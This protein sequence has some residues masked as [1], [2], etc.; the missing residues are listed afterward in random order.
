MSP[1]IDQ[2]FFVFL[3]LFGVSTIAAGQVI[4]TVTEKKQPTRTRS[5]APAKVETRYVVKTVTPTTGQ[6]FVATDPPGAVILLEPLDPRNKDSRQAQVPE[7]RRDWVFNDLRPGRYRVAATKSEYQ[8]KDQTITIERNKPSRMTLDLEPIVYTV[9][10][11]TNVDVGEL[12][13]GKVGETPK[14][15]E[16]QNKNIR[17]ALPAG[18]YEAEITASGFGYEAAKQRF[19]VKDNAI[20][21]LPL[22][23][24]VFSTG[25]LAPTWTNAE[26]TGW[27]TPST[28]RTDA[29]KLVVKGVGVALPKDARSRYY[30]DFRLESNV[31]MTNGVGISFALRARDSQ[32]YYL[33]Q[34]TGGNNTDESY[35]VRLFIVKNGRPQRVQAIPISRSKAAAMAPGQFFNLSIKVVGFDI[36]VDVVD[37]QTG[38]PYHLGVLTDPDHNFAVGAVGIAV[39]DNE[40]NVIERFVVCTGKCLEG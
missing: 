10:V 11:Q 24:I 4:G 26:L 39:K 23:R 6:L 35:V 3:I 17:L 5:D 38:E 7:D 36:T 21:K 28:W 37:N 1:R 13:Y 34:L 31:N 33:V 12:K 19:P 18:D 14:I 30:Q 2:I 16:F 27:E 40:E 20:V 8:Q 22:N 25:T 15:L 9:E 32:N 29:K